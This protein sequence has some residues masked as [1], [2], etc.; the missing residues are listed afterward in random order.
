M[1]RNGPSLELRW[2]RRRA[3]RT[4]VVAAVTV[5]LLLVVLDLT[6]N[7]AHVSEIGAIRRLFNITREDSLPS[8]FGV[9]QTSL[10]TLTLW[11]VWIVDRARRKSGRRASWGW[12]A[13][14]LI[15]TYLTVDDGAKIHERIGTA[16]DEIWGGTGT[17]LVSR[18]VEAFPSYY[19]Q[20]VFVP[21]FGAAGLFMILYLW[22]E[23]E[24]RRAFAVVVVAFG[25]FAA[26]VVLDFIEG[27]DRSHPWNL[28]GR[29]VDAYDFDAA[30]EGVFRRSSFSLVVHL[31][32]AVEESLE[33]L[34]TTLLWAVSLGHLARLAPDL[35]L[36]APAAEADDVEEP[37]GSSG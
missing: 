33:M 6:V 26:A 29:L 1:R 2:N 36:R 25:L 28:Y 23:L 32:K 7:A 34:A 15:F 18:A 16:I 9:A 11:A 13:L 8:F 5:E 22:R 12:L 24:D 31:F 17:S 27:L 19:W 37:A 21:L 4:L 3:I 20:L 35:R 10:L 14:A 30:A